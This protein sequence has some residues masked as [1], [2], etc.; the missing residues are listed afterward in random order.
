[1]QANSNLS[2]WPERVKARTLGSMLCGRLTLDDSGTVGLLSPL[3]LP[4]KK[5]TTNLFVSVQC[6]DLA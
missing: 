2:V 6:A 1:M 4:H 3:A 5:T